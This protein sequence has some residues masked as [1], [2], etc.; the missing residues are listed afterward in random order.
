[1]GDDCVCAQQVANN[2]ALHP[3]LRTVP[4][5]GRT[6]RRVSGGNLLGGPSSTLLQLRFSALKQAY[7]QAAWSLADDD[8]RS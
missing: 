7:Q 5:G 1:M 2:Q 3:G 6:A 8:V 4:T